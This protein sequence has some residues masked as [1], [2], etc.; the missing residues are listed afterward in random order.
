M[1]ISILL[2]F[3]IT[4]INKLQVTGVRGRGGQKDLDGG[5]QKGHE[6]FES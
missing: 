4:N 1:L 6:K 3:I 5:D 2:I